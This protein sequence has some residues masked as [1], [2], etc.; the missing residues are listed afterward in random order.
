[1]DYYWQDF[2]RVNGQ[3][4]ADFLD[5]SNF[6]SFSLH[7]EDLNEKGGFTNTD[8][9]AAYIENALA[10][11]IDIRPKLKSKMQWG[12]A[13]GAGWDEAQSSTVSDLPEGEA[14]D[15]ATPMAIAGNITPI[16]LWCHC[17]DQW[18]TV[19]LVLIGPCLVAA[20]R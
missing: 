10:Y 19:V 1:M 12:K 7:D 17:A 4:G 11:G 14:L 18:H 2:V 20:C 8:S 3:S 9:K 5:R 13:R 6:I 15:M 16:T